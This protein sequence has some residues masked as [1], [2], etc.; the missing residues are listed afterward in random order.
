MEADLGSAARPHGVRNSQ[1]ALA[2]LA[3]SAFVVG[4]C[5][6]VVVGLVDRIAA[7]TEVS[8]SAAGQV[9]TAYALG[10]GFGGPIV[11]ALTTRIRRRGLLAATIAAFLA[12]NALTAAAASYGMLLAARIATGAMQGL[13]IGVASVVAA[14]LVIPERR[15]QAMS[16]VFGGIAVSTVLGVPLGTLLG[17]ALG[18]RAAFVAIIALGVVALVCTLLFIPDV[19]D[20]GSGRL[21]DQLR[22]ACAPSVLAMLG[23]GLLLI[24]GQFAAFTYLIPYL[25]EETGISGG[26]VGAFLLVYGLAS[27]VG[28]F[29]GGRLAD[30]SAATTLV[31][32]NLLL[33]LALAAFYLLGSTAALAAVSLAAWGLVGFGLVPALQLRVI[34]LAGP[35]ADLAAT[36]SASAVNLGIALGAFVGG[37]VVASVGVHQVVLTG[38]TIVT[39][40]LPATWATRRLQ[41]VAAH[42]ESA[43][44]AVATAC[45]AMCLVEAGKAAAGM[46]SELVGGA[47]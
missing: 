41:P 3:V 34:A 20:H 35:N 30:R 40:A 4:T 27:A 12:G 7:S 14:S 46:Q 16:M 8:I 37:R 13:F 26:A 17:Q 36:L 38:L 24:G 39:V 42:T 2:T 9:V 15:G 11:A 29:G 5:E 28:T 44:P 23:L 33:V 32:A 18:W 47:R 19:E 10:I 31:V 21:A 6:L 1:L 22:A 43:T 25:R 45:H